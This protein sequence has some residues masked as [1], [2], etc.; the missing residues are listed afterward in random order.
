MESSYSESFRTATV[1]YSEGLRTEDT[2]TKDVPLALL[3][4]NW[5]DGVADRYVGL[6][7]T[8][9]TWEPLLTQI[10][11]LCIKYRVGTIPWNFN[12]CSE[13]FVRV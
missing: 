12:T 9:W 7:A 5:G 6:H 2:W 3:N 4:V 1:S 8:V 11:N 13:Y 10:D